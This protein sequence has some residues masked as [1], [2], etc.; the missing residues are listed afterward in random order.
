MSAPGRRYHRYRHRLPLILTWGKGTGYTVLET[1]DVSLSGVFVRTAKTV[2]PMRQLLRLDLHLPPEDDELALHAMAVHAV[3]LDNGRERNP[4]LGLQLY[5]NGR[6]PLARWGR[7]IAFVRQSS[8][9]DADS[10][11]FARTSDKAPPDRLVRQFDRIAAVLEV[12]LQTLD[13]LHVMHTRDVSKGGIFLLTDR[14]R[15]VGDELAL[16]IVHPVTAGEFCVAC[17]VRRQVSGREIGMGV[18]LM[19]MDEYRR[20]EW[21]DFVMAGMQ[22]T[23]GKDFEPPLEE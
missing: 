19:G 2:V 21:W 4:G 11:P 12:R 7:F 6:E 20:Q 9:D 22:G 13:D 23:P 16:T 10:T 5:G 3:P 17:V 8:P 18:E 1:E 14:P 15:S